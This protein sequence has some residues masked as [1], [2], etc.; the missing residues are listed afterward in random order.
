MPARLSDVKAIAAGGYHTV[1]L[2]ADGTVV[3]WGSDSYELRNVPA[4][5]TNVL[6]ISGGTDNV[7][8]I[9]TAYTVTF[10]ANGGTPVPDSQTVAEGAMAITPATAPTKAGF[11][12]DGWY[13]DAEA[14]AFD[15]ATPINSDVTLNAGW[16]APSD[17]ITDASGYITENIANGNI[18]NVGSSLNAKLTNITAE[19]NNSNTK[20]ALNQLHTFIN[21]V[22]AQ[23][24]KK[25]ETATADQLIQNA[26]LIIATINQV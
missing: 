18:I 6:S 16:L 8:A 19:L 23:K 7:F 10:D 11:V 15:F 25:I 12:F 14:T 22:A 5:L 3:V 24:G 26:Q 13:K 9:C 1:A 17:L 20:A 2:K 21:A 4:G